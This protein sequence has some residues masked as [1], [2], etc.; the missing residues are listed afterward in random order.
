MI[1]FFFGPKNFV[2]RL[3]FQIRVLNEFLLNLKRII[4]EVL[5]EILY[6]R[7]DSVQG[8]FRDVYYQS[9]TPTMLVQM[10]QN[11]S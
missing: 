8:V 2:N 4:N 11:K 1:S 3:N 10:F 5:F 9:K 6:D 7:R